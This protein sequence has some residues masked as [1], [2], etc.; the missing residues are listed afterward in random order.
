MNKAYFT[1]YFLVYVFMFILID[2]LN[3]SFMKYT[4]D[5]GFFMSLFNT[6]LSLLMAFLSAYLLTQTHEIY[7]KNNFQSKS[8]NMSYI[9]ILFAI[10]TY[11]CTP[12]VIAFFASLGISFSVMI[13]PFGGLPYKL[14]SLALIVFGIYLSQRDLKRTSCSL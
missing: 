8:E 6:G 1:R 14:F 7:K 5:Y 3:Y 9:S 13:L 11:G 4:Q 2:N 10:L 12:C